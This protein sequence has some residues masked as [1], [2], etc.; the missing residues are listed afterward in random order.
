MQKVSYLNNTKKEIKIMFASPKYYKGC[1]SVD[2]VNLEKV[3]YSPVTLCFDEKEDDYLIVFYDERLDLD[4][5]R[6]IIWGFDN[7]KHRDA[8]L[9]K[10]DKC[11]RVKSWEEC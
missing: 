5:D 1:E 9:N 8:A 11:V 7:K 2:R 10:I 3:H 6:N 4:D